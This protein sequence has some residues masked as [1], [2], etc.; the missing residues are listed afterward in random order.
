[1]TI[2]QQSILDKISKNEFLSDKFILSWWTALSWFY[3]FHRFSDDLDFFTDSD[4]DINVIFEFLQSI[5]QDLKIQDWT[6]QKLYDRNIFFLNFQDWEVLKI[7]RTKYFKSQFSPNIINWI[8]I[9]NIKDIFL[10]KIACIF[11]RNDTKD[12]TDMY[13]LLQQE[14]IS[15]DIFYQNFQHKFMYKISDNTLASLF[16]DA[17]KVRIFDRCNVDIDQKIFS[18]FFQNLSKTF[19]QNIFQ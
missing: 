4:F 10:N 13:F 7:E 14:S 2:K 15:R 9:D 8:K 5:K 16:Y 11:D 19:S 3:L 18:D 12:W 6:R 1:L 17:S